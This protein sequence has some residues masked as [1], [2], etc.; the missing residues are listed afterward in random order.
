MNV[1]IRS[2]LF[3]AAVMASAFAEPA[4]PLGA[5]LP[6]GLLKNLPSMGSGDMPEVIEITRGEIAPTPI[7]IPVFIGDDE[8][9]EKLTQ[10]VANDLEM[11]GRFKIIGQSAYIQDKNSVH[12]N[13]RFADWRVINS[14]I[15]LIAKVSSE[16]SNLKVDFLVYDVIKGTQILGFSLSTD[17]SKGRKLGHMI[18]DAVYELVTGYAGFFDSQIVFIHEDGHGKAKKKS[19]S[20]MDID[21]HNFIKLTDGKN[22]VLTPRF[23]PSTHHIAYLA[24]KKDSAGVYLMNVRERNTKLLGEFKGM[25][26]APRFSPDGT[27]VVMS[28]TKGTTTAIYT[29]NINTKQIRQLT[30]H[31]SIDTSPCFSPD[32]THIVFTSDRNGGVEKMFVMRADGSNQHQISQ[33]QGQYSQPIWSPRGDMIAFSKKAGGRYFL[34]VMNIDGSNERLIDEGYLIEG[35]SWSPNGR[36]IT[37]TKESP[38][39]RQGHSKSELCCID[40]TGI[41]R[42]KI[43][44]PSNASDAAWSPLQSSIS[45]KDKA[46]TGI[47]QK[48]QAAAAAA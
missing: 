13:I 32:G 15:L 41:V 14:Q 9:A 3:L 22:L 40:L 8:Y 6:A 30:E 19:L 29:Y 36:Y 25:T 23:S 26:F 12:E 21:G 28:L 20:I 17:E 38:P 39:N 33:G 44:T 37:Y 2:L 4:K 11:C 1:T 24:F 16:G 47:E 48:A 27:M 18:A 10:V 34:G 43:K 42:V 31:V 45:V 7:A 46:A 35:A 5:S